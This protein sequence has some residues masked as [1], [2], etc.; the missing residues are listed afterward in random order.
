MFERLALSRNR[1][2]VLTLAEKGHEI[3][4]PSDLIKA[5]YVVIH[6]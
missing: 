5:H 4:Q 6:I 1:E 3:Q 2:G